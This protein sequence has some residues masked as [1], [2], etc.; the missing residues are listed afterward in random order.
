MFGRRS[1][2]TLPSRPLAG[3][4]IDMSYID[5]FIPGIVAVLLLTSPRLFTKAEGEMFEQTKA[6]LRTIGFVLIGVAL[7][8]LIVK[9]VEKR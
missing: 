3:V 4:I 9:V 6:K 5:V 8:Y 7:L 2:P 1:A